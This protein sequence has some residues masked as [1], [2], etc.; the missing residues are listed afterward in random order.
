LGP[1]GTLLRLL[2][3]WKQVAGDPFQSMV[4]VAGGHAERL[5]FFGGSTQLFGDGFPA[6]Q[7]LEIAG[8]GPDQCRFFRDSSSV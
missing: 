5:Q 3:K 8:A 7:V 4:V 6:I 2:V 1:L